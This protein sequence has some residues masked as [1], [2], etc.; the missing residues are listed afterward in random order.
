MVGL[1][2]PSVLIQFQSAA[3]E[4]SSVLPRAPSSLGTFRDGA[5]F[6]CSSASLPSWWR[7][8]PFLL[9]QT[10]PTAH[11]KCHPG[12]GHTPANCTALVQKQLLVQTL[13]LLTLITSSC[14]NKHLCILCKLFACHQWPQRKR[15]MFEL[16]KYYCDLLPD[17]M[18][19][20]IFSE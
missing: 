3:M 20:I 2:G 18:E 9:H 1:E 16:T 14:C 10:S 7:I 11:Q 19:A 13:L 6:L 5:P 8:F 17:S 15:K 12:C 4:G